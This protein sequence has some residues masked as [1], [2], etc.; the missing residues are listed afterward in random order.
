M[1]PNIHEY[2]VKLL[3]TAQFDGLMAVTGHADPVL[4]PG[5]YAT[6]E[7]PVDFI[8]IGNQEVQCRCLIQPIRAHWLSGQACNQNSVPCRR[9]RHI[10]R[11]LTGVD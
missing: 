9:W 7:L 4:W 6:Q 5:E 10:L 3:F 11:G 2:Q 1:H 8:V